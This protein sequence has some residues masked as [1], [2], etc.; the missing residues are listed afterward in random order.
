MNRFAHSI[1]QT[2]TTVDLDQTIELFIALTARFVTM[3]GVRVDLHLP[4]SPLTIPTAPY[5]L[6]NLLWL[7]LDFSMSASGEE[8]RVELVVEETENSVRI[9]FR[10]L[11]GLSEVLL[12]T[13][14]SDREK[15]LLAVLEAALTAVP[16]HKEVV[17]RLSK[18]IDNEFSR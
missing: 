1:D 17:L 18:K 12:E 16:E 8:K 2:T 6:L 7:C 5:Y 11:T 13:F 10:R 3:R 15:N 14:P 9:R 4:A